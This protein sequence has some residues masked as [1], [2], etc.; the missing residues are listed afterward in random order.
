M[1]S[2]Y[3]PTTIDISNA[4][5]LDRLIE[6]A[7]ATTD[8]SNNTI[9]VEPPPPIF[10]RN[11]EPLLSVEKVVETVVDAIIENLPEEKP[12]ENSETAETAETAELEENKI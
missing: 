12:A 11:V 10:E 8:I 5:L 3:E 7:L 4:T 9:L 2:V 1:K 6:N